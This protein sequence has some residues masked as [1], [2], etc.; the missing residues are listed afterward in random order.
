M[1][2]SST[3]VTRQLCVLA[4]LLG[5]VGMHGLTGPGDGCHGGAGPLN[6]TTATMAAMPVGD[7][8]APHLLTATMHGMGS[9]CVSVQPAGWPVMALALLAIASVV[10]GSG[11]S[12]RTPARGDRGRSPPLGGASLLRRVCV[13]LT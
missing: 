6:A 12:I 2:R 1:G 11:A 4:L 7:S 10:V 3:P 8:A 13:S 9:V 5:L